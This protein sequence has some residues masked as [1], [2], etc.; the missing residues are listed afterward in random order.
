MRGLRSNLRLVG[1]TMAMTY[2]H[3][4]VDGFVLFTILIQPLLVA[5]LSLWMLRGR[6]AEYAIYVVVGSG[7]TGL[8][9]SLL[10]VSG[11][12]VNV[13]RWFGTLET[14]TGVPSRLEVIIFG[15]T[16]ANVIQ[17]VLSMVGTYLL[18]SSVL[19]YPLT[20]AM[21]GAFV[22]SLVLVLVA[23]ISFGLIISPLFILNPQIQQFQ[24]GIEFPVYV[25]SGF[26]FPILMLPQWTR[27]VSYA[28]PTYWAAKALHA[29]SRAT[30]S[31]EEIRFSWLM[32]IALS[33]GFFL[34]SSLLFRATV[35]RAKMNGTLDAR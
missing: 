18:V 33:G 3:T 17:S 21:P 10:F 32:L 13:E 19:G 2:K 16:L 1:T 11:N 6:G 12:A 8:W 15:K 23:F 24:N 27:P 22:L 4:M 29:A 5:L 9:S 35:R 14:L 34:V 20:V 28:L 30:E 25:L 26:L 7:M 31:A